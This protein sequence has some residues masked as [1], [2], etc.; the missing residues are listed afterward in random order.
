MTESIPESIVVKG[1]ELGRDTPFGHVEH[2][3]KLYPGIYWVSTMEHGGIK[4]AHYR[5]RQ[6]PMEHRVY[7]GWYEEDEMW[8]VPAYIFREQLLASGNPN[9]IAM[10]GAVMEHVKEEGDAAIPEGMQPPWA[11]KPAVNQQQP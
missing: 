7:G 9:A 11:R 1:L 5:N 2:V 3:E 10:V 8:R 6:V 4:L